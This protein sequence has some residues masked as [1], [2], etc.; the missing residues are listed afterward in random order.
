MTE[1]ATPQGRKIGRPVYWDQDMLRRAAEAVHAL[2]TNDSTL[3]AKAALLAA[4]RDEND[5]LALLGQGRNGRFGRQAAE[6]IE[7]TP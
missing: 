4:I 1:D 5:V 3:L 2:N 6:Q 7:A